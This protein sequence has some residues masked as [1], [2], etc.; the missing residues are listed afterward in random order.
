MRDDHTMFRE[1]LAGMLSSSYGDHV[2]VVGKT[3]V[4]KEA[5]ALAREK[6][7]DVIV[8]QVDWT[9]QKAKDTLDQMREGSLSAPKVLILTMFEEPRMVRDI[10]GLGA[11]A[12][13]HKSASVEELFA[14]VRTA[15]DTSE[16]HVVVAM[17]QWALEL[18]P[19]GKVNVPSSRE[20]EILLLAARG[21]RN[22]QIA[23]SLQ[24]SEGTVKRHLANIYPKMEVKSRG[25]AVR[26]ALEDEWFTIREIEAAIDDE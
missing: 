15:L 6:N 10:M 17:P 4:G 24:I 7:P 2:E 19:D 23:S 16:G 9:L 11:N 12:Y 26:K 8:M 14:A 5:V 18:S 22:R 21:M 20:M 1:G 13:L 3:N 25:E